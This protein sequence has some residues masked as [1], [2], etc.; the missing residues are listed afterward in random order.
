MNWTSSHNDGCI[1]GL[2]WKQTCFLVTSSTLVTVGWSYSSA[3]TELYFKCSI[4]PMLCT[5]T[6]STSYYFQGGLQVII[7]QT[8]WFPLSSQNL[9]SLFSQRRL[10]RK[11]HHYLSCGLLFPEKRKAVCSFSLQVTYIHVPALIHLLLN[12]VVNLP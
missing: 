11:L 5:E 12:T 9:L 2:Y 3:R 10:N 8:I 7:L 6:V 1:S 4:R